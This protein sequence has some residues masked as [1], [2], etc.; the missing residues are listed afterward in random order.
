MVILITS[1]REWSSKNVRTTLAN[2]DG[3]HLIFFLWGFVKTVY[4]TTICDL[5]DLQERIYAVNNV[6]PQML[7]NTWV[8]VEYRLDISRESNGNHVEV[9]GT[10]GKTKS[11]FSV[12]VA[13]LVSSIDS[14]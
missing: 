3:A 13:T 2:C 10:Y 1:C 4:R 8:V 12:F 7:H 9:N 6:I 5:A 14:Y 11:K